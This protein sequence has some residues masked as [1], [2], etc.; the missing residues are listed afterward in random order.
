[1]YAPEG[2]NEVL[3]LYLVDADYTAGASGLDKT[4]AALS[5]GWTDVVIPVGA[6]SGSYDPTAISQLNIEILA[7]GS[8]PWRDPTLIYI[9]RIWSTNGVIDDT[10]TKDTNFVM[11]QSL[12]VTGSKYEALTVMP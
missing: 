12:S 5:Q 9:D 6:A 2:A 3:R 1:M 10:F 4:L 11:S 8:G 7:N